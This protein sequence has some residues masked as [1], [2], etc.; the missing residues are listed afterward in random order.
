MTDD[1]NRD[2]PGIDPAF[3]PDA[4]PG[5]TISQ[6]MSQHGRASRISL[7]GAGRPAP[8]PIE[9]DAEGRKYEVGAVVAKGGMGAILSAKDLNC[10]RTV[11]MKVMLQQRDASED[12]VVRF[13]EEAQVT[14]QL[15]HPSIVP[16]HELGMDG[17]GNVFYTMKYVRGTTLKHIINGISEGD[18]DVIQQ[19]PLPR[20]LN[21]FL[22]T[23]DALAFAHAKNVV[24]RDL[25]PENVMVGEYGEV[26]VMDWGL[27]KVLAKAPGGPLGPAAA[28]EPS[29]DDIALQQSAAIESLRDD[30]TGD[31]LRT[32]D[33]QVMGTPMFMAPEQALGKIN[34]IDA[35]TDIYALGAILYNILALRP[36]I[37]GK[38]LNQVLLNVAK[39]NVT[40]PSALNADDVAS[41]RRKSKVR[42]ADARDLQR[43]AMEAARKSRS[44][45]PEDFAA[46]PHCPAGRIPPALSSVAMKALAAKQA[47]RYQTV[48]EL[49]A[50][51]EAFQGGFAT[52]AEEA[53]ALKQ[54]AL[55]LKRHKAV[56]GVVAAALCVLVAVV[57]G[58]VVRV[59]REKAIAVRNAEIAERNEEAATSALNDLR[60]T[61]PTFEAQA[62]SLIEKLEFEKAL[63]MI[64]HAISLAPENLE[65]HNL[66]GDLL[67][68]LLK[69][70]Q[71]AQVYSHVLA[72]DKTNWHAILNSTLCRE[73]L[74][75]AQEAE[76]LPRASLGRLYDGMM[77]QK[78][79]HEAAL[80]VRGL[81]RDGDVLFKTYKPVLDKAGLGHGFS[82]GGHG[83]LKLVVSDAGEPDLSILK[84]IPLS[85]LEINGSQ[86]TDIGPLRGM[87][88]TRLSVGNTPLADISPL[89]GMRLTSLNLYRT[90]VT[91]IRV[92][93]GMP[94]KT[95]T[96]Y[97]T[98]VSDLTPLAGMPLEMLDLNGC[99]R[100]RDFGPLKGMPLK[101][102][103]LTN[104]RIAD[105]APLTGMPLTWLNLGVCRAV[106]DL[107][108]LEGMP[109]VW[110]SV[111]HTE[112]SDIAVLKGMPLTNLNIMRT[113]ITDVSPLA[114]LPLEAL[115]L[116]PANIAK[117]MDALRRM[118]SLKIIA[119]SNEER[120]SKQTPAEFW[121]K[122]DAGEYGAQQKKDDQ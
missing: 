101:K 16:V 88:L 56:V 17:S 3:E 100:V 91:D 111:G 52:V 47:D 65:Y 33:G 105:L 48:K 32:L 22:R 21:L 95:L 64:S 93:K 10:R 30:E 43:R 108:P 40:P 73:V 92:L 8:V 24:H 112:V 113:N 20:L 49:Q 86:V 106:A 90:Q 57:A 15:E 69:I 59:N 61:A 84:G 81:K 23:C 11:A 119:T 53:G 51:I 103:D 58:F 45:K 71:A 27:A 66:K 121:R 28:Q 79:F 12:Q 54:L 5:M 6:F 116:T 77:T 107:R 36:P 35:R 96:L 50:D 13:I 82:V 63:N 67:Q 31:S 122:Y 39:G 42:P 38:S 102:L 19:Y 89:E 34:E 60:R 94:L 37:E 120:H 74:Q 2:A 109:L 75:D 85:G 83:L 78:R 99:K 1:D 80:I 29:D 76:E 46:F 70:G 118:T 26:L 41:E 98:D 55:L 4:P 68:S 62:R 87:P 110:L 9:T 25:K 115:Q 44:G 18:Q 7:D 104:A 114:E 72:Q 117:G 14:A 97:G